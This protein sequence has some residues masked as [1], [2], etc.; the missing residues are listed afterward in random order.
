[1]TAQ[2]IH[3]FVVATGRLSATVF[4]FALLAAGG[5]S[6]RALAFWWAFL[7]AHTVHFAVVA[8]F[9]VAN[10]GRGL[11][12]GGRS[13]EEAGGWPILLASAAVFYGLALTALAARR[14]DAAAGRWLRIAGTT[15]TTCIGLM[16]LATYVPLVATSTY[17]ILPVMAIGGALSFYLVR[18]V[19][20][21]AERSS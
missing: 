4:V 18:G 7:C 19:V 15:A 11:F 17:F 2:E 13:L 21:H 1:M 5:G 12:P 14:A 20:R 10:G 6:R 16:F 8:W 9:A 3:G